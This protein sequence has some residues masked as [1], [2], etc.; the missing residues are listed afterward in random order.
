MS[1]IV[2]RIAQ[3]IR[4][5]DNI[6]ELAR[7]IQKTRNGLYNVTELEGF[8]ERNQISSGHSTGSLHYSGR[9]F[10][11]NTNRGNNSS[12]EDKALGQLARAVQRQYGNRVDEWLGPW[13]NA[14][15]HGT[16]G[17]F[18]FDRKKL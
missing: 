14:P 6:Q 2:R 18:G 9:A 11:V 3:D 15:G 17:H 4:G 8:E 12:F 5:A 13:N 7:K 1:K 10:D 16:H